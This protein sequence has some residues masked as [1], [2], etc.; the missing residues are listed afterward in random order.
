MERDFYSN[1]SNMQEDVLVTFGK[2]KREFSEPLVFSIWNSS[3]FV[4]WK[5]VK[6]HWFGWTSFQF[7]KRN[8]RCLEVFMRWKWHCWDKTLESTSATVPSY[9][10]TQRSPMEADYFSSCFT[11]Q[12]SLGKHYFSFHVY[13]VY[14]CCLF[15]FCITDCFM[16]YLSSLC[17]A[18]IWFRASLMSL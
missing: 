11:E 1:V 17:I 3:C 6:S 12:W 14:L 18:C 8:F 10:S 13:V 2:K 15:Y 4:L 9:I 16:D 5:Y 7:I